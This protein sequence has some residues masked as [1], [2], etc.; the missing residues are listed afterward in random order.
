MYFQNN[1]NPLGGMYNGNGVSQMGMQQQSLPLQQQTI[2]QNGNMAMPIMTQIPMQQQQQLP[3]YPIQQ[4][5]YQVNPNN[6]NQLLFPLVSM[7]MM[8]P[9]MDR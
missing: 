8:Q 7:P 4:A 3:T 6:T 2:Y 5:Q 1:L 9:Y